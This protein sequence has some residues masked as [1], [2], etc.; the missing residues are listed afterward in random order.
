[1]SS[2]SR[3]TKWK[4]QHC[5]AEIGDAQGRTFKFCFQCGREQAE[6]TSNQVSS[7]SKYCDVKAPI[8]ESTTESLPKDAQVEEEEDAIKKV[9]D[10]GQHDT[11]SGEEGSKQK[12]IV[13]K[14]E[15]ATDYKLPDLE[16]TPSTIH[17]QTNSITDGDQA[18]SDE[19]ND[20]SGDWANSG[21]D[22]DGYANESGQTRQGDQSNISDVQV[23]RT[24]CT[25][26]NYNLLHNV[27]FHIYT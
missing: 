19:A 26:I 22:H 3:G 7:G 17:G 5:P 14:E 27:S 24:R 23:S 9:Q 11:S 12:P 4:C 21:A 13:I 25:L 16:K 1:M 10:G 15:P 6:T 18:S 2:A 8:Q 20:G